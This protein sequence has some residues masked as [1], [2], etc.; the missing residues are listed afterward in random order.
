[1]TFATLMKC[2][3]AFTIGFYL[4]AFSISIFCAREKKKYEARIARLI[5]DAEVNDGFC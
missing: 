1:M 5:R 4:G 2:F 3:V